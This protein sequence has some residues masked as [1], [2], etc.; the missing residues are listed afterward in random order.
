LFVNDF[1]IKNSTVPATVNPP[2]ALVINFNCGTFKVSI[3]FP[4]NG[5]KFSIS[6]KK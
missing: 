4:T 5:F 2:S 1:L 6:Q 3:L